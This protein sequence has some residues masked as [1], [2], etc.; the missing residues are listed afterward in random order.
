MTIY[1]TLAAEQK[2]NRG[3]GVRGCEAAN[4]PGEASVCEGQKGGGGA[5]APGSVAVAIVHT[6]IRLCMTSYPRQKIELA[7][8]KVAF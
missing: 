3:A 2:Y 7:M 4:Y 8:T 6:F 1:S 5:K